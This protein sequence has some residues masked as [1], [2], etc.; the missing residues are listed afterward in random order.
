MDCI[1]MTGKGA[2]RETVFLKS[3]HEIGTLAEC[4][5]WIQERRDAGNRDDFQIFR[6]MANPGLAQVTV[7]PPLGTIP[8]ETRE[9]VVEMSGKAAEMLAAG[10]G[11]Q[12]HK[13]VKLI[14][15][16][17]REELEIINPTTRS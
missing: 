6:L 7:T 10:I 5:A 14:H 11:N 1:I 12:L 16:T 15:F 9:A 4:E 17:N 13:P 2:E 3:G 8:E